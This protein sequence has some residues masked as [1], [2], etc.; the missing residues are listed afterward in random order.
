M[1]NGFS[2][3]TLSS[4]EVFPLLL[5]YSLF[6]GFPSSPEVFPLL[7]RYS[8]SP[9]VFP[10]LLRFSLFSWGTPSLSLNVTPSYLRYSFTPEIL[11]P[12][13]Q[14]YSLHNAPFMVRIPLL[15][16]APPHS[17]LNS[18]SI[19]YI[20]YRRICAAEAVYWIRPYSEYYED[21]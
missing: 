2:S 19:I 1:I 3:D 9:E 16:T 18:S 5:R 21:Y 20:V 11:L 14:R 12:L 13:P 17:W 8:S 6:W 10:L 4:S 7:L 15:Y